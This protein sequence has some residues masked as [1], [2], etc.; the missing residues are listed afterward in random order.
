MIST[1]QL[2]LLSQ[3]SFD[4]E[5]YGTPKTITKRHGPSPASADD[6]IS[7]EEKIFRNV[8]FGT[9]PEV[10]VEIWRLLFSLS[11][12][13]CDIRRTKHAIKLLAALQ[14]LFVYPTEAMVNLSVKPCLSSCRKWSRIVIDA[15][16]D[17]FDDIVSITKLQYALC[18]RVYYFHELNRN[19][20]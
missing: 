2:L 20:I 13:D 18:C 4:G 12:I 19:L 5:V 11:Y 3:V 10:V 17:M 6:S 16:S 15:M 7:V 9:H 1:K 8:L 14:F